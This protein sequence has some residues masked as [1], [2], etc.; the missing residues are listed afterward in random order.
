MC[1]AGRVRRVSGGWYPARREAR[2][3]GLDRRAW[4]REESELAC[5]EDSALSISPLYA[6]VR[7]CEDILFDYLFFC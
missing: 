2:I 3:A 7:L 6:S 1:V 5:E 4:S